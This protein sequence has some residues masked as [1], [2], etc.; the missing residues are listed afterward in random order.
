MLPFA[1]AVNPVVVAAT[2][3]PPLAGAI[4]TLQ[5][6]V[7]MELPGNGTTVVLSPVT[8]TPAP[9]QK[10]YRGDPVANHPICDIVAGAKL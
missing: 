9:Y 8:F 2:V 4:V 5:G 1:P 3:N 10:E 7:A 6:V